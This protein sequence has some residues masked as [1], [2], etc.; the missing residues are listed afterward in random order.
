[1]SIWFWIILGVLVAV[2]TGVVTLI[3]WWVGDQWADNEYKKFGTRTSGPVH[4]QS[5]V[6]PDADTP[7][8]VQSRTAS[9][10]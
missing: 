4:R 3:W 6:I 8:T 2:L 7:Q 5:S 9:N 10:D 1:M